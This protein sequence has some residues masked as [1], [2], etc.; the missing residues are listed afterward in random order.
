MSRPLAARSQRSATLLKYSPRERIPPK[1][2]HPHRGVSYHNQNRRIPLFLGS[3]TGVVAL[4][5]CIN[6]YRGYSKDAKLSATLDVP[7]DVSDRYKH[8]ASRFDSDVSTMEWL[9]GIEKRRK[10]LCSKA[11]GHILEVSAGTGRNS[12]FLP[13]TQGVKSVTLVDKNEEMIYEARRKWPEEGN[14]WFIRTSFRVQDGK[15]KVPFPDPQ[16]FDT[17][18]QTMGIC[19]T[20]DPEAL[21]RNMSDMTNPQGGRI[22]LLEHGKSDHEWLNR[23]MD[24]VA[25]AHA[26]RYGC[27]FNKDIGAIVERSGLEI[28][29]Q[30]RFNFGTIWWFE[31]RPKQRSN[32]KTEEHLTQPEQTLWSSWLGLKRK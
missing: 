7:E 10:E 3:A 30:K 20:G 31:L 14:A 12:K 29:E 21:L 17:V 22:L 16:G 13:L 27:W 2:L 9:I 15:E 23:L 25:P 4:W 11:K 32:A 1:Q 18:L 28:V 24:K 5:Y 8:I 26:D 6:L 19:S